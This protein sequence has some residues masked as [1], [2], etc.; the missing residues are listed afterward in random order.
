MF[1]V[2]N[3]VAALAPNIW[4]MALARLIPASI[5]LALLLMT[6]KPVAASA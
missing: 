6:A 2:A 3:T 1:A 5:L 4:V